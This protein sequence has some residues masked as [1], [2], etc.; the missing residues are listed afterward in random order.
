[1]SSNDVA[2]DGD[3]IGIARFTHAGGLDQGARYERSEQV[4]LPPGFSGRFRLFVMTDAERAVFENGFEADKTRML[5]GLFNVAPIPYADLVVKRMEAPTEAQSGQSVLLRWEVAHEGIGLTDTAVWEDRVF[6]ADNAAGTGRRLPGPFDHLGFLAQGASH[7]REARV[8]LPVDWTGPTW[9][10]VETP[11]HRAPKRGPHQ[12][13]VPIRLY[14]RRQHRPV[15]RGSGHALDAAEPC[16][17]GR[18]DAR[19]RPHPGLGDGLIETLQCTAG[20]LAVGAG[21]D[22]CVTAQLPPG[23][24][25]RHPIG[26]P[27]RRPKGTAPAGRELARGGVVFQLAQPSRAGVSAELGA[28]FEVPAFVAGFDGEPLRRHWFEPNGERSDV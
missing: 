14:R 28:G 1:V 22:R 10:F 19:N 21:H 25:N 24:V 20:P 6:I 2:G 26:S 16:R 13:A 17:F 4:M 9:F 18:V 23:V 15:G 7:V 27:D 3:G 12:R 5:S 8:S 11:G